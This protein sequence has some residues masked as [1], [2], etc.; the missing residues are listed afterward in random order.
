PRHPNR[1]RDVAP[2]PRARVAARI[3]RRPHP[4]PGAASGDDST[5]SMTRDEARQLLEAAR[6]NGR[7]DTDPS[8]AE[9]L[10]VPAQDPELAVQ[11]KRQ[12]A[13]DASMASGLSSLPVPADLRESILAGP[14]IVKPHFWQ[15]WRTAAAAAAAIA[16]LIGG[17]IYFVSQT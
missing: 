3:A 16:L 6:A 8:V 17:A 12:R 13:F 4:K 14:K 7:D 5:L 9:A 15:D 2:L 11:L 1:H 10:R